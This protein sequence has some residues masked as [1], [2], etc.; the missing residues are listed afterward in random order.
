MHSAGP[1]SGQIINGPFGPQ[2]RHKFGHVAPKM[3]PRWL[4]D[5]I[6]TA[7]QSE[8]R[9]IRPLRLALSC[10]KFFCPVAGHTR[11]KVSM[12]MRAY[13]YIYVYLFIYTYICAC[14]YIYARCSEPAARDR[15]Q[16]VRASVGEAGRQQRSPSPAS[17]RSPIS[18]SPSLSFFF[19]FYVFISAPASFILPKCV[20]YVA[21]RP[22]PGPRSAG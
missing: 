17:Y 2:V 5:G 7:A 4:Q 21:V 10:G 16:S 9:E 12:R 19:S 22:P 8:T 1:P 3:P 15:A 11:R 14:I 13:I 20:Q 18:L 6:M